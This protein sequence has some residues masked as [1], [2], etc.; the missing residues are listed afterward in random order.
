MAETSYMNMN[1]IRQIT[2]IVAIAAL[3]LISPSCAKEN[4]NQFSESIWTGWYPIQTL[5]GTTLETEDHIGSISLVF[6][7]DGNECVVYTGIA[8]MIGMSRVNYNADWPNRN[9]FTLLSTA[10]DQT[11][12]SYSGIITGD[13]LNLLALNCDSVATTYNLF[14][15]YPSKKE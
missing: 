8:G 11:I 6:S 15:V 12:I 5:N 2:V 9:Q 10:G 3:C 1:V 13:S 4:L 14:R 7:N